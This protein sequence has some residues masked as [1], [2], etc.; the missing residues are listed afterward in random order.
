MSK[1][2]K[3]FVVVFSVMIFVSTITDQVSAN[4]APIKIFL[5]YL[6]EISNYGSTE[7][8]GTALVSIGEAWVEITA[9]GVPQLTG[10][11]YEAWLVGAENEEMISLGKFNANPQS[12]I[13]YFVELEQLPQ[14][15]Y[16]F[17]V[18]TVEEDPD[19]GPQ[20][21]S[22]KTLAGFFPNP[23]L[24]IVSG[25]P[26]PTLPPGVTPTPGSPATLPVTGNVNFVGS[27]SSLL[28][29]VG[30]L[31]LGIGILTKKSKLKR[32]SQ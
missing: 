10:E 19:P 8:T 26:T 11:L 27:I 3:Q 29:I 20:A 28:F 31:G 7:A 21:D 22:R 30:I 32:G 24:L 15:E 25:T 17:L 23:E 14:I 2:L 16:R 12:Q 6:P 9:E 5:N 13:D 1:L 4:G 18:I